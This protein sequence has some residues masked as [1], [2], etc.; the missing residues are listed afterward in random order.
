MKVRGPFF[1]VVLALAA[2]FAIATVAAGDWPRFLGPRGD[3]TSAET[4]LLERWS[5]NGP[6]VL[7]EKNVGAGYGAPS[8]RGELL[9]LH[10]R[11]GNE[12]IV[13]AMNARTGETKW[14]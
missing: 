12:E 10:H 6:P 7:W 8:V 13:E 2:K 11:L 5:T 1:L 3:G 9:V 14:Q 4:N